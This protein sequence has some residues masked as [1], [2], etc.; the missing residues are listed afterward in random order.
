MPCGDPF[1][2]S[3]EHAWIHLREDGHIGSFAGPHAH[4][5]RGRFECFDWIHGSF[6]DSDSYTNTNTHTHTDTDTDTHTDNTFWNCCAQ[7][8]RGGEP[9]GGEYGWERARYRRCHQQFRG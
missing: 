1:S 6:A 4:G 3:H 2:W 7:A 9:L 8:V 5:L